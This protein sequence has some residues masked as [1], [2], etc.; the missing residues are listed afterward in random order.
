MGTY[1]RVADSAREVLPDRLNSLAE[2]V[3]RLVP[4]RRNP[5]A[6]HVEKDAIRKELLRLASRAI[7]MRRAAA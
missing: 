6:F 2:R 4:D 1:S 5:E 7:R 3:A